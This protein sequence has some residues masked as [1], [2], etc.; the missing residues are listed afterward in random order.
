MP[1]D[2]MYMTFPLEVWFR[3]IGYSSPSTLSVLARVDRSFT[4]E[5]RRNLYHTLFF[6]RD[7]GSLGIKENGTDPDTAT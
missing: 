1:D 4:G 5:A 3:I 7:D 6:G 2:R